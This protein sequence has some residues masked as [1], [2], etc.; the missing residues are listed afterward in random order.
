M[1]EWK[2]GVDSR[3]E[4][5]TILG[6]KQNSELAHIKETTDEI[7]ELVKEQNGRVRWLEQQTT[8]IKAVG[9]PLAVVFSGFIG[10]LF[11][12]R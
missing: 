12:T 1:D 11:K 3:L 9:V 2:T 8:A 10:W 7:K 4:E 6:A 5:L